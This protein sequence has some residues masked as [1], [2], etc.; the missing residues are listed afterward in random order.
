MTLL[1][2]KQVAE[3]WSCCTATVARKLELKK[4]KLSNRMTR[5]R[6]EDVQEAEKLGMAVAGLPHSSEFKTSEPEPTNRNIL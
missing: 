2:R 3:R 6:L 1:S 4:I 5:Y